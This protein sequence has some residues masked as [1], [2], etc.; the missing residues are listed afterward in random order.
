VS[1]CVTR[2]HPC[3]SKVHGFNFLKSYANNIHE[4]AFII[5]VVCHPFKRITQRSGELLPS[6]YRSARFLVK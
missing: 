2:I 3:L 4:P 5:G 1:V 6:C